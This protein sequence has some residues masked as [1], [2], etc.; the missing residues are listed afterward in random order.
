MTDEW[1]TRELDLPA[2]LAR[3]GYHGPLHPA[4]RTL[5]SALPWTGC[6]PSSSPAGEAAT[7]TSTV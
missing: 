1:Q 7:A 2:Y 5:A 6:R 4:A 3:I